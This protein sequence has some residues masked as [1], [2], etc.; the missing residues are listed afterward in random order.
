MEQNKTDEIDLLSLLKSFKK[1]VLSVLITLVKVIEFIKQNW[2]IIGLLLLI[3]FGLGYYKDTKDP[4]LKSSKVLLKVNFETVNYVY[5]TVENL[6]KKINDNDTLFLKE[7]G[8]SVDPKII[9][10]VEITPLLNFENIV[11]TFGSS[12]RTLEALVKN[13]EISR[14]NIHELFNANL[15]EHILQIDLIG[16][17]KL[18]EDQVNKIIQYINQNQ[19]LNN[20]KEKNNELLKNQVST[21]QE[22]LLRTK[23]ILENYS[24]STATVSSENNMIVVDKNFSIDLILEKLKYIENELEKSE[25][26]LAFADEIAMPLNKIVVANAKTGILSEK[27]IQ[28]PLVLFFGFLVISYFR[29]IYKKVK[30]QIKKADK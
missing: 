2:L 14:E 6:N 4:Q 11:S 12:N 15:Q 13:L 16:D 30:N 22:A 9:Q 25:N 27:K 17:N 26:K 20:L 3:G 5:A 24:K 23:K 28:F 8:F 21:Y 29:F 19:L 18:C 10:K 7:T 1:G